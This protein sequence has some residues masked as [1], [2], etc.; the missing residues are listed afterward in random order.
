[1]QWSAMRWRVVVVFISL[2]TLIPL[3]VIFASIGSPDAAIWSHLID[4]QLPGILL[5]TL[6]LVLGVGS[7]VFLIGVP[8]AWLVSVY[9]FPGRR[10]FTWA[11]MLPL[12]MPA[13]VMAFSQLG[14][15]EFTGPIQTWLRDTYGTSSW[16][17]SAR[18]TGGVIV[19]LTLAF[20]PYVYLLARNAFSTMGRRALEV[21]QSLGLS[22]SQGFWRVALPM[23]RPWI[24]GGMTLALME[25]LA[26]FGAVAIFN[27]D[28]FTNAIYKAWFSFF[29]LDTAKQLASLLVT[30]VFVLVWFEQ[31]ARGRRAYTQAG[32]AAPLPRLRLGGWRAVGATLLAA[33]VF[34]L[35]FALPVVQLVFWAVSVWV[36]ELNA[37]L[38]AYVGRSLLLS[39]MAAALVAAVALLLSYAQRR[40]KRMTTHA[41]AKIATL[42]YAVPGTVLAVGVFVPIAWLDN[43]LIDV[44]K[45]WLPEGTTAILKGT[46]LIMLLA[47]VA[48]FLAVGHSA[49][50]AAMHRI[51]A[52][53]EE[54]AR[55]LGYSGW[56][57]AARLHLPLLTG[58]ILTAMLMVFVDVMKEMPIT[59]M[60]R[61]FG[62]D[63]LS[64]RI[65]N[66]TAEGQWD[67]A[68]LPAIAIVLAGLIPVILL[69]RQKDSA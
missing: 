16:V 58:G 26:D 64:V 35:A 47:F 24:I 62:W 68:A 28:T 23:A 31:S 22:R 3:S 5:N 17:P 37:D 57:L 53:Q 56:R 30:M 60:T 55:I 38:A 46:L 8:L 49:I 69:S 54:A 19:I 21:G 63:T 36:E 41:F 33:L 45:D 27:Y 61:P 18:S 9:D 43:A 1:M 4:Y 65:F 32:R 12:A 6:W 29:S 10:F 39:L 14:L 13:Y 7:G 59:L 50:D 66:L 40:D 34:A 25:T 48:R 20:Y 52:S 42:G 44:F 67:R 11:L 2:V 51:T 15:L